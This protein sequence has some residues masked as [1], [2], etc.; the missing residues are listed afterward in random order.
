MFIQTYLCMCIG[1]FKKNIYV[2]IYECVHT[3]VY[4]KYLPEIPYICIYIHK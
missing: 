1:L 4:K 2:C 3:C